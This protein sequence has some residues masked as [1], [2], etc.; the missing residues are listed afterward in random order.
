MS[1]PGFRHYSQ[2]RL[3]HREKRR[4]FNVV[5]AAEATL[6]AVFSKLPGLPDKLEIKYACQAA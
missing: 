4:Y 5:E 2:G 3:R 1:K 6:A